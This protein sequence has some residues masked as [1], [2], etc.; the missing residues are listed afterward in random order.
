MLYRYQRRRRLA[1]S[2]GDTRRQRELGAGQH[3]LDCA[4]LRVHAIED[5]DLAT[6]VALADQP[7]KLARR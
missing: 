2:A 7:R 6:G 1:I 5:R 4:R 3:L